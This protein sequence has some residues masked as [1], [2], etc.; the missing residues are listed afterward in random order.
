MLI[1]AYTDTIT[2]FLQCSDQIAVDERAVDINFQKFT[3][4]DMDNG[5]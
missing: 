4:I 5:R 1:R 2:L 3:F